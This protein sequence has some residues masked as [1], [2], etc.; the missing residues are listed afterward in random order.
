[1]ADLSFLSDGWLEALGE[2][3]A[4]LPARPGV[5]GVVRFVMTSTPHGKVQFRLVSVDG[6]VAELLP[7]RD[8]AGRARLQCGVGGGEFIPGDG[9]CGR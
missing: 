7:G 9:G 2:A 3:G 6:R 8:G 4:A 5:D 1:M